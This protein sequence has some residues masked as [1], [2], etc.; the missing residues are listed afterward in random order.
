MEELRRE[1]LELLEYH[2]SATNAEQGLQSDAE[3]E[4]SKNCGVVRSLRVGCASGCG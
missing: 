3:C 1:L 2:D 4:L